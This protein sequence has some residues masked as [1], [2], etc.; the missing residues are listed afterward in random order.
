MDCFAIIDTATG[1]YEGETP[2]LHEA[3]RY[4]AAEADE[5]VKVC[6]TWEIVPVFPYRRG[7]C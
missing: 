2:H 6:P 4:S 7:H 3:E 1:L 5:R